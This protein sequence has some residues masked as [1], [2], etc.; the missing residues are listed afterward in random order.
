MVGIC[1]AANRLR[2]SRSSLQTV[3]EIHDLHRLAAAFDQVVDA[4]GDRKMVGSLIIDSRQI[5]SIGTGDGL[6][7]G[8]GAA[9]EQADER[10]ILIGFFPTAIE[11]IDGGM[12]GFGYDG[13][14]NP[15]ING[16]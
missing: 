5:R 9:G 16:G 14:G 7:V 2:A 11:G 3:F 6:G 13:G 15:T 10:P 4:A 1:S 12:L 8:K